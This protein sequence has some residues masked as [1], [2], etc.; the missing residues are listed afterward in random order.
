MDGGKNSRRCPICGE[1]LKTLI[2]KQEEIVTYEVDVETGEMRTIK[3]DGGELVLILCGNCE[4][5]LGENTDDLNRLL[6][7][8]E[9]VSL[10]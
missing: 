5:E 6:Y 2:L 4:S 7:G 1:P 3:S 8:D 10:K 9:E